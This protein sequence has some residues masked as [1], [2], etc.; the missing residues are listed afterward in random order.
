MELKLRPFD[1]GVAEI[2]EGLT[3]C[4]QQFE[5]VLQ[6]VT[7]AEQDVK[8]ALTGFDEIVTRAVKWLGRGTM[9]IAQEALAAKKAASKHSAEA[10]KL[11]A[12]G[13]QS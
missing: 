9:R 2:P 6:K 7:E 4:K 5:N 13:G 12:A 10:T 8:P 3:S 1:Y 11:A